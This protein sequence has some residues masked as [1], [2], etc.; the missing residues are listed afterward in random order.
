MNLGEIRTNQQTLDAVYGQRKKNI[1][2]QL[3]II[4]KTGQFTLTPSD[5]SRK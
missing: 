5:I 3:K 4:S 1:A 2:K